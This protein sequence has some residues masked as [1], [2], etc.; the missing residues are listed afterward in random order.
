LA[1]A[2]SIK[3]QMESLDE[4]EQGN[5]TDVKSLI[6]M[7]AEKYIEKYSVSSTIFL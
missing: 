2:A 7:C 4:G 1:Q 5:Y 6:S 3:D